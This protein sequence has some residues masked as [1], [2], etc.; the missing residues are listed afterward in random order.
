MSYS[1]E[2]DDNGVLCTIEQLWSNPNVT[3]PNTNTLA[4]S[5]DKENNV[6][7]LNE[8]AKDLAQFRTDYEAQWISQTKASDWEQDRWGNGQ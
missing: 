1:N 3:Y 2:C 7:V 6:R 5:E 8:R 4:G